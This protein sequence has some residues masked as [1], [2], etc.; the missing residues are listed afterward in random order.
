M[1]RA[2]SAD[3]LD[4]RH[5][6]AFRGSGVVP[7]TSKATPAGSP[8]LR[9]I[10]LDP[11]DAA[12]LAT[13]TAVLDTVLGPGVDPGGLRA[14]LIAAASAVEA[15]RSAATDI[16]RD[17]ADPAMRIPLLESVRDVEVLRDLLVTCGH[18]GRVG[19][20]AHRLARV[21]DLEPAAPRTVAGLSG[22]I[23]ESLRIDEKILRGRPTQLA[24]GT[25]AA[26]DNRAIIGGHSATIPT[27]PNYDVTLNAAAPNGTRVA[28]FY[29]LLRNDGGAIARLV[30]QGGKNTV[31]D[32]AMELV[33]EAND[34]LSGESAPQKPDNFDGL[35]PKGKEAFTKRE[36]AYN[37]ATRLV[38]D[39]HAQIV[40]LQAEVVTYAAK[41][42]A[43]PPN[44]R[45]VRAFV[46]GVDDL[47]QKAL[48]IAKVAGT[49]GRI[50]K[51]L[52]SRVTA[53]NAAQQY[54]AQH[55]PAVSTK[56]ISTLP[57]DTWS[58]EKV[59]ATGVS[60]SRQPTRLFA[61]NTKPSG[62]RPADGELVRTK[63]Q[64]VVEG[65]VWV[66]IKDDVRFTDA[67][68]S[69]SGGKISSS[70][71]T[72]QENLPP[73]PADGHADGDGFYVMRAP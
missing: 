63:H 57:P 2:E 37:E 53:L 71:P 46:D 52:E 17:C 20:A 58:D 11:S 19:D 35:P 64:A 65:I 39:Q 31:V 8:L 40:T 68:S 69:F 4:A 42:S 70:F 25:V 45:D 55:G 27:D 24:P 54:F 12:G 15:L 43:D 10:V 60:V 5:L 16:V 59:L 1:G 26:G 29:R 30:V 3:V 50:K 48:A 56:K 49:V 67:D 34:L 7:V 23:E 38:N 36:T 9:R 32:V 18:P 47:V 13:V 21:L 14:R 72:G 66:A 73:D 33:Q 6:L 61:R 28:T 62:T 41:A 44:A 22:A 51:G